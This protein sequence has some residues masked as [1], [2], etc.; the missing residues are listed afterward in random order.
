MSWAVSS[1]LGARQF[2]VLPEHSRKWTRDTDGN[3]VRFL[4]GEDERPLDQAVD[5]QPVLGRVD[6]RNPGMVALVVQRRS[7]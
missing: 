3:R 5:H 1:G 6:R 2:W 4:H 7:G